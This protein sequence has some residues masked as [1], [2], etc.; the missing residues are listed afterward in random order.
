MNMTIRATIPEDFVAI[1]LQPMQILRN[2]PL[3]PDTVAAI[4]RISHA[5][6]LLDPDGRV[7]GMAG[8]IEKRPNVASV[9]V[10]LAAWA[11]KHMLAVTRFLKWAMRANTQ[12]YAAIETLVRSDFAPGHRWA[13][14]FGFECVQ[15][16]SSQDSDGNL[17][18]LYRRTV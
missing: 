3:N 14:M 1:E 7:V 17:E 10:Y 12:G 18:D 8:V 9:W 11:G 2:F 6:T 15:R 5:L 16:G 13:K 4:L